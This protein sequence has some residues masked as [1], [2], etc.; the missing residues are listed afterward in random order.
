MSYEGYSQFL[1]KKGHLWTEDALMQMYDEK[2]LED[3]K[4]PKCREPAVWE[5]MVNVTNG[6]FDDEGNRVDNFVELEVKSERSG[7]CSECGEKHVC[8]IRR[9]TQYRFRV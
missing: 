8:D 3:N 6:S 5:N 4:C 9:N 7:I 2:N 1:C